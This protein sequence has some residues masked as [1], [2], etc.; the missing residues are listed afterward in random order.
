MSGPSAAPTP[1]SALSSPADAANPNSSAAA[2]DEPGMVADP[3]A[4]FGLREVRYPVSASH[5]TLVYSVLDSTTRKQVT[6]TEDF[7]R[8]GPTRGAL[9]KVSPS[10]ADCSLTIL[11][12]APGKRAGK[13]II[14][15]SASCTDDPS[16]WEYKV[17][18]YDC[19]TIFVS[20]VEVEISNIH[21]LYYWLRNFAADPSQLL[22]RGQPLPTAE[23]P[24][25]RRSQG[26]KEHAAFRDQPG[27]RRWVMIDVD[28]EVTGTFDLPRAPEA[29]VRAVIAHLP[30]Y[31]QRATCVWQLSSTAWLKGVR[32]H[33][34]YWLDR[35]VT[36]A[37]LSA[38]LADYPVDCSVFRCVQPHFIADPIFVGVPDPLPRRWGLLPG[39]QP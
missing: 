15:D 14:V 34:F 5:G 13:T 2:E 6:V 30:T 27:G 39:G 12:C 38:A 10:T 16:T 1:S 24:L 33:L 28:R 18:D 8:P 11:R 3:L 32:V 7:R 9:V 21:E 37:E 25:L 23:P 4:H 20:M 29:A 35:Q 26:S 19:G 22:I 17:S 36:D 31:L